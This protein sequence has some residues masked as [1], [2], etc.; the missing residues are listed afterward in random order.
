[1]V[2]YDKM[3]TGFISILDEDEKA[4]LAFGMIPHEKFK[5]LMDSFFDLYAEKAVSKGQ[6]YEGLEKSDLLANMNKEWMAKQENEISLAIY[7]NARMV[8]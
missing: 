1:M 5:M 2:N 8:I 6:R 3:A 7:R 4:I